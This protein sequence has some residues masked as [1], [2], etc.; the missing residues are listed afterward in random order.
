MRL[1]QAYTK[2]R[3]GKKDDE[4]KLQELEKE[5]RKQRQRTHNIRRADLLV[6]IHYVVLKQS[7]EESPE[8]VKKEFVAMADSI[9]N[10]CG[11]RP[12]DD[13]YPLDYLLLQ[14]FGSVDVYTLT[15]VLE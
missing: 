1:L 10:L 4:T 14:C 6:L 12:M 3:T 9:L 2:C 11:M 8:V 15:D 5:I 13:K 7:G